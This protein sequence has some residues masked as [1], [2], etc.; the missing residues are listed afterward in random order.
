MKIIYWLGIAF[1][2]ML[3]LNFLLLTAAKLLSA[4]ALG[5]EELVGLG[6][7]VFG[8]VA[9]GILYRRRP[10]KRTDQPSI[11]A[12]VLGTKTIEPLRDSSCGEQRQSGNGP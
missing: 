5:I 2:W 6:M 4:D 3:P 10:R 12:S 7:A 11:N 1:L 9:G 8:G